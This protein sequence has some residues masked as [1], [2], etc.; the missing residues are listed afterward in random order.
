MVLISRSLNQGWSLDLNPGTPMSGKGMQSD[1]F[2]SEPNIHPL[3]Y[4]K[5]EIQLN[6]S[7]PDL[8][9]GAYSRTLRHHCYV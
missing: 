2:V 5:E 8:E 3:K 7:E 6:S 1:D 4:L 9:N